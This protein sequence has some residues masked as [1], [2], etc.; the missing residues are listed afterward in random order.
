MEGLKEAMGDVIVREL[1]KL[2]NILGQL[3]NR[4]FN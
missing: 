3:D 4:F 1:G 2:T